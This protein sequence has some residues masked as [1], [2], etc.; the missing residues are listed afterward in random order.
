MVKS[1]GGQWYKLV[2]FKTNSSTLG[3]DLTWWCLWS[4]E[5]LTVFVLK[6][7]YLWSP[8]DVECDRVAHSP[9]SSVLR[10][11]WVFIMKMTRG[12]CFTFLS[13]TW[14]I[15]LDSKRPSQLFV[16]SK[17]NSIYKPQASLRGWRQWH[18]CVIRER[19]ARSSGR[20]IL[21]CSSFGRADWNMMIGVC[22]LHD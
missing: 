14:L 20:I 5:C 9:Y 11:L 17:V 7:A 18:M 8:P 2:I 6:W 22:T 12:W 1:S 21:T 13:A 3:K 15:N 4:N 16:C 19:K 10:E